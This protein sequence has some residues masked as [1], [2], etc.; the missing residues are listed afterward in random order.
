MILTVIRP[1]CPFIQDLDTTY[2]IIVSDNGIYLDDLG[3]DSVRCI[4]S[5][6]RPFYR[7]TILATAF[8]PPHAK[9]LEIRPSL[10]FYCV[11]SSSYCPPIVVVFPPT[12]AT[13]G[14]PLL[15]RSNSAYFRYS[16]GRLPRLEPATLIP[17][18]VLYLIVSVSGILPAVS[19]ADLHRYHP[20]EATTPVLQ[21]P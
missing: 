17:V 15:C 10:R 12:T 7:S 16:A 2:Y 1:M 13:S 20:R 9:A 11:A 3:R 18:S 21:H 8:L 6:K 5:S 19:L 4:H 14:V